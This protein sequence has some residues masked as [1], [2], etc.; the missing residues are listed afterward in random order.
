M[1]KFATI[2][3]ATTNNYE[4][5]KVIFYT[6]YSPISKYTNPENYE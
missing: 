4:N 6:T 5:V 1:T 2:P 3:V